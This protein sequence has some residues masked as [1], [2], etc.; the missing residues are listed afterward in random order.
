MRVL[1][2]S[3]SPHTPSGFA[4][5][6]RYLCK[7]LTA[8]GHEIYYIG[9]QTFGTPFKFEG[10]N[11]LANNTG[12]RHAQNAVK[13]YIVQ[14]KPD[15]LLT[16]WDSWYIRFL[17]SM[18][19]VTPWVAWTPVDGEPL[20]H[21]TIK[22]HASMDLPVSFAK[23]G[24]KVLSEAGISNQYIPHGVPTDIYK[25]LPEDQKQADRRASRLEG[26][27]PIIVSV[28]RNQKR[29][30]PDRLLG[31]FKRFV[32]AG[33]KDAFLYLH[34]D[35]RDKEGW[36]IQFLRSKLG[37]NGK[38]GLSIEN[39]YTP[40]RML[41]FM[42]G[43]TDVNLNRVYNMA[44]MHALATAGE[45]FGIPVLES[46]SAGLPNIATDCSTMPELIA[47]HGELVKVKEW[48]TGSA[49][50]MRALWDMDDACSKFIKLTDD[51]VLRD[52][53]SIKARKHAETYDWKHICTQWDELLKKTFG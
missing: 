33:Y 28:F 15:V 48:E 10:F 26:K 43:I 29:K 16:L 1:F 20:P 36:D 40:F 35:P 6:G 44:H 22:D 52:K 9:L 25:P 30:R 2:Y 18:W 39:P 11:L 13:Q 47:D 37:L 3:D 45:G 42:Q 32:D 51:P 14:Y 53:Y 41:S 21:E 17:R 31:A 49:G 50:V 19:R 5:A 8:L 46:A 27:Y 24:N 34:T 4:T 23:F 7:G 38:V 12:N